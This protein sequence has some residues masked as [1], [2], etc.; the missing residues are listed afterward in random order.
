MIWNFFTTRDGKGEV[1][2]F[3]VYSKRELKIPNQNIKTKTSK[4]N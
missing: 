4:C 1:D 3:R 2:G